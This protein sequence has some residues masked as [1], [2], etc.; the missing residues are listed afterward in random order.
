MNPLDSVSVVDDDPGVRKALC[1]LLRAAGHTAVAFPTPQE[2]LANHDPAGPGC[3]VLDMALPGFNGLE[4]QERLHQAGSCAAIVFI[5]GESDIPRSV[6]AMK[7]GAVDFLTKP[8]DDADLL[9]AVEAALHRSHVTAEEQA[10][11][12]RMQ[13]RLTTLTAR[14]REVFERVVAGRLNKVIATD[15]GTV[16][17]TVKVHR[18]R[19]MR[20]M[21]A[22][23]LADLV[24]M[25]ERMNIRPPAVGS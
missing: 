12:R 6:R 3:V 19:V 24:R 22:E 13:A 9:R 11:R 14:E 25:A 2:F 4:L 21:G 5:S 1:H 23:S 15:L 7:A 16:E 18:A 8:F 20:K 17:K 10:E